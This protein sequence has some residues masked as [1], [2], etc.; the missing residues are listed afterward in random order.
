MLIPPDTLAPERA[1]CTFGA[2]AKAEDTLGISPELARDIPIRHVIVVMRENRSFDHLF[3]KLHEQGQPE[4]EPV[5]ASFS[6]RAPSG[7][8][9]VPFRSKTTCIPTNADHQ[10]AGMHHGVNGGAMDGFVRNAANS[11]FT[12]GHFAMAQYEQEDLPFLTWMA[13]TWALNDRHFASARSGTFPNRNFLMLGTN[14]GV[15]QTDLGAHPRKTT[16]TLFQALEK[17]GLTWAAYSDG[18]LLS[19]A[20]D[21][22]HD[23]PNCF[24]E[25]DFFAQLDG[26]QL[27]N[28][29][30]I[31]ASPMADD[32]HPPAD[33][34]RGEA[35][36]RALYDRV[37][38]SP[39]WPRTAMI[40]FYDEGGG[41]ADHVPPPNEAC[42]AR[43]GTVDDAYFELGVR[44]PLVVISPYAKPHSVSHVV[45][46]H[47]A[48][49][50]FIETVFGLPALTARDANSPGLLDMFDFSC[51]P[52]ML[53]P[54]EPPQA[55]TGG[56]K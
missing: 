43:P 10:W 6:N 29:V 49:T 8:T 21:W 52:P 36:V 40:W 47:T 51:T 22:N 1:A 13:S 14:D 25:N 3:S 44:V 32:D 37:V 15:R 28:V 27:P 53:N 24:C 41:F 31:D 35:W 9:V 4:V 19:G 39:Q 17:A 16:P 50:R 11:T 42:V 34:Q 55:G 12:D 45:Q 5:P 56:C 20:L 54:P 18:E 30:F 38:H 23:Q 2:G 26:G 48:V 33:V 46:E 7:K